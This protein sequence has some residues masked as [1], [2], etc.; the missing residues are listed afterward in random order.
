MARFFTPIL[1]L[2]NLLITSSQ[3]VERISRNPELSGYQFQG[4][5]GYAFSSQDT[6]PS[7]VRLYQVVN[8]KTLEII[9]TTDL[10]E[11]QRLL[12]DSADEYDGELYP[13]AF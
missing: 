10:K 11:V 7:L 3:A 9:Y 4:P 5:L 2:L 6:D 13:F 8:S 1:L 12:H